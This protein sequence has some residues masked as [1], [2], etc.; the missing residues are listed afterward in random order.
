MRESWRSGAEVDLVEKS[1][2]FLAE[3]EEGIDDVDME[4]FKR[5]IKRFQEERVEVAK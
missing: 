2:E 3:V 1:L 5:E 4:E